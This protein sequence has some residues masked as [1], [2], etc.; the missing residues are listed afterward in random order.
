MQRTEADAGEVD[1]RI[2][3]RN[4]ALF[5]AYYAALPVAVLSLAP[6]TGLLVASAAVAVTHLLVNVRAFE[7]RECLELL[8]DEP[9]KPSVIP[10]PRRRTP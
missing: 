5:V 3:R 2:R 9:P 4:N 7:A 10:S 6:V 8:T 1:R